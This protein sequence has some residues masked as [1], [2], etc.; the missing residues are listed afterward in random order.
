RRR[1]HLTIPVNDRRRAGQ[2]VADRALVDAVAQRRVVLVRDRLELMTGHRG[3][4][5][6]ENLLDLVYGVLE[7]ADVRGQNVHASEVL[8]RR[9]RHDLIPPQYHRLRQV[10]VI[11]LTVAPPETLTVKLLAPGTATGKSML[12]MSL[13]TLTW[14]FV[15]VLYAV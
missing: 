1:H 6:V 13:I 4:A 5:H 3:R 10:T 11:L 14:P 8:E 15:V 2:P 12:S 9:L 7:A